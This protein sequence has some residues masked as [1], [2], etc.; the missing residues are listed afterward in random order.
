LALVKLPPPFNLEQTVQGLRPLLLT[1][2]ALFIPTAMAV[3][4]TNPK[5]MAVERT[6]P[7]LRFK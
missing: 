5:A 7:G 3:E 2:G 1:A 4:R 6:N